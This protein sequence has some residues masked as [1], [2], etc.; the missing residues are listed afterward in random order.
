[1]GR[2]TSRRR[3]TCGIGGNAG[4]HAIEDKIGGP[5][6]SLFIVFDMGMNINKTG[7]YY[8]ATD[9]NGPASIRGRDLTDGCDFTLFNSNVT[10]IPCVTGTIDDLATCQHEVIRL[11]RSP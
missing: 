11:C 4:S 9:I 1:M 8:Q 5:G 6:I 3:P 10:I 7:G 2:A